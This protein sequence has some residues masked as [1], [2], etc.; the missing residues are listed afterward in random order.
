VLGMRVFECVR[1]V[2]FRMCVRYARF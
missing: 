1:Y 2:P